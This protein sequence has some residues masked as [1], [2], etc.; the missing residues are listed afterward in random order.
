MKFVPRCAG[1][2][3]YRKSPVA[4]LPARAT[5]IA[6]AGQKVTQHA[7]D[8]RCN[9]ESRPCVFS[10]IDIGCLSDVPGSLGRAF[11]PILEL[12]GHFPCIHLTI[13]LRSHEITKW[14]RDPTWGSSKFQARR[15][16]KT[17]EYAS[18]HSES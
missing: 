16:N 7:T 6:S 9:G 14:G 4:F 12:F 2:R 13:I 5:S 8:H 15:S 1:V 10:H 3:C 17:G 18:G 11:L